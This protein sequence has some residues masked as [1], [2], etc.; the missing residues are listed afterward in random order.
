[1]FYTSQKL[2]H[3]NVMMMKPHAFWVGEKFNW[4]AKIQLV[5]GSSCLR[6]II[7]TIHLERVLESFI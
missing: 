6:W 5:L 2:Y 7:C 1:L 4:N 3:V